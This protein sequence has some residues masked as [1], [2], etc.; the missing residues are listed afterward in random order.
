M[1]QKIMIDGKEVEIYTGINDNEIEDNRDLSIED[2][3]TDDTIELAEVI[4]KVQNGD[5]NE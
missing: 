2:N 5:E 1:I 3:V 4:S